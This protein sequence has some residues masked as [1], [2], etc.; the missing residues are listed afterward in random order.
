MEPYEFDDIDRTFAAGLSLNGK[1]WNRPDDTLAVAGV[2]NGISSAHERYL[3]AGGLGI[4]VGDGR[5]QHPG[6]ENILEAYYDAA[7]IK[8]LHASL[9]YQL[10]QN[11]AYNRDR[12]PASVVAVRL[13]GQF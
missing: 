13:H 11:P 12:G 4:L 6:S 3:D 2:V 5:L 9:D 8:A 10:I 7:L 1:R